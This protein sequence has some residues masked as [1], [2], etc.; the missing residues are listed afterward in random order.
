MATY[1]NQISRRLSF[2]IEQRNLPI[3]DIAIRLNVTEE[4]INRLLNGEQTPSLNELFQMA[5]IIGVSPSSLFMENGN[6]LD[7]L[8]I[9][10]EEFQWCMENNPSMRGVVIGYLAELKLR[11]FFQKDPRVSRLFKYDD[12]DRRKKSDLVIEYKGREISFE[13]KSLQTNTVRDVDSPSVQKIAKFQCDAS[14]C[15]DITLPDG[16]IIKTTLLKYGD[17][18][19]LA[20]NLFAFH[21]KWEYAFALNRDLPHS[22][23]RKYT[24]S[25]QTQLIASLI[26]ITYP[27]QPPFVENPFDL[28][29][30]IDKEK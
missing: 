25:Q 22:R 7:K 5:D 8:D 28:L 3:T 30:K 20:V 29:D 21:G 14:D 12:H 1:T 17:F 2:L 18:D 6:I 9:T 26:P 13:S 27:I 24:E 10:I 15:R 23:S 19:I 4:Y 11:E 16:Q